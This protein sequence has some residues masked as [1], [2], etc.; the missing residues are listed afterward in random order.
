MLP[1]EWEAQSLSPKQASKHDCDVNFY[2]QTSASYSTDRLVSSDQRDVDTAVRVV[3]LERLAASACG[4]NTRVH[5]S[6]HRRLACSSGGAGREEK[7]NLSLI[8]QARAVDAL[9]DGDVEVALLDQSGRQC[10]GPRPGRSDGV[11]RRRNVPTG[12]SRGMRGSVRVVWWRAWGTT[13]NSGAHEYTRVDAE[14]G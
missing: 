5:P 6:N 8:L 13:W 10:H 4:S 11:A 3:L 12:S 14:V 1:T 9:T 7:S 2:R